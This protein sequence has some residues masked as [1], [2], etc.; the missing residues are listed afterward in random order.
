M[1]IKVGYSPTAKPNVNIKKI[2]NKSDQLCIVIA[3]V[4]LLEFFF[5]AKTR[6]VTVCS[7]LN[8]CIV[9]LKSVVTVGFSF[10]LCATFNNI[11]SPYSEIKYI[12]SIIKYTHSFSLLLGSFV[13]I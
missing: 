13:C 11:S 10:S 1:K 9:L 3:L 2:K 4:G 7:I 8:V 12:E 5:Q 6:L